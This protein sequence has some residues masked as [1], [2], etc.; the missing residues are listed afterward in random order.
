MLVKYRGLMDKTSG[1][2]HRAVVIMRA[3]I[4]KQNVAQ[5]ARDIDMDGANAK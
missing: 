4:A 2:F 5:E 1:S 3:T